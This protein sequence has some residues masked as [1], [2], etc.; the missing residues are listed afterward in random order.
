MKSIVLLRNLREY[1]TL[2]I[3]KNGLGSS[4]LNYST[5]YATTPPI[6]LAGKRVLD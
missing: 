6:G 4:P 2:Q 3:G 5:E 1:Y